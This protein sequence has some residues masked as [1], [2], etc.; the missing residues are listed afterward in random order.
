MLCRYGTDLLS[1]AQPPSPCPRLGR[2]VGDRCAHQLM[3]AVYEQFCA[4]YE[5]CRLTGQ[6]QDTCRLHVR[7]KRLERG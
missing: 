1:F 4:G 3:A 7:E 2:K 5:R 6:E